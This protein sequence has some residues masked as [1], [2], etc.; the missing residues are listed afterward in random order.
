MTRDELRDTA[1]GYIRCAESLS[2]ARAGDDSVWDPATQPDQ[3]DYEAV[4]RAIR[5]GLASDAWALVTEVLLQAPDERSVYT[6]PA[7]LRISCDFG[8]ANW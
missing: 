4:R 7:R 2:G 6:P 8:A 5:T 1:A 3:A